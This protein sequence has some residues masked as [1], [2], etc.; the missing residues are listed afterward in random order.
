MKHNKNDVCIRPDNKILGKVKCMKY[1]IYEAKNEDGNIVLKGISDRTETN[2]LYEFDIKG[3]VIEEKYFMHDESYLG[4]I[5]RKFD[6]SDRVIETLKWKEWDKTE[7]K[8]KIDYD[9]KGNEL[10]NYGEN[11]HSFKVYKTDN[12]GN[13]SESINYYP[14]DKTIST[15]HTYKFD[16]NNRLI[17]D[18][19][20]FVGHNVIKC[21]FKY[22]ESGNMIEE[23][24][25]KENDELCHKWY[26]TYDENSVL[27]EENTFNA[28]GTFDCKNIIKYPEYDDKGNWTMKHEHTKDDRGGEMDIVTVR[29]FEYYD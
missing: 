2:Q 9:E 20:D 21:R 7:D 25:L 3:N 14:N 11:Q 16:L 17:E 5:K 28:Y 24:M 13:L 29:K 26:F 1:E 19:D 8:C 18:I 4:S 15:I 27:T 22:D 23:I 6:E 10:M 12:N